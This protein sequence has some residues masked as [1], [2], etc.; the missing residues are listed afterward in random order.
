MV[1][2]SHRDN[3][4]NG[5]GMPPL[6][7]ILLNHHVES[8]ERPAVLCFQ[9]VSVAPVHFQPLP[10]LFSIVHCF[11]ATC[12]DSARLLAASVPLLLSPYVLSTSL[13]LLSSIQSRNDIVR[14]WCMRDRLF[15][16]WNQYRPCCHHCTREYV[17]SD[18]VDITSRLY[19][20]RVV[21]IFV[22][23][24]HCWSIRSSISRSATP[25]PATAQL[26]SSS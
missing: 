8:K 2:D 6:S 4:C 18:P 15:N 25:P 19:N 3:A 9:R 7:T 5:G 22:G 26:W 20:N 1:I 23:A 24:L 10:S 13:H 14:W 12:L 21:V 11:A 17:H 16:L